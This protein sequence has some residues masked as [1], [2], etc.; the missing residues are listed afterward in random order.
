MM[1]IS[2]CL[3]LAILTLVGAAVPAHAGKE[4]IA[5]IVNQDVITKS[6]LNDRMKLISTSTGMPQTPELL[7]KLRPQIVNMLVE[8][9]LKM[10]EARRQKIEVTKEEIDAGF[11]Q[12]SGQN[13]IPPEEFKK[14]LKSHGIQMRTMEDQIRAQVAWG[15]VIQKKLRP[16][17]EISE[18]D[19]DSELAM[20]RDKIGKTEYR[21]ADIYLPVDDQKKDSEVSNVARRLVD[22]LRDQPNLFP[23]VAQQF[24]QA[25]GAQQGGMIGWISEGQLA[26]EID[27]VLPSLEVGAI[28]DAIKTMTGY[29]IILVREKRAITEETLPSREDL[30]Q[31]IGTSRL[32]RLQRRYLMDLQSTAYIES[33]V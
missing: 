32:D 33:R 10:Q 2:L 3:S 9:E 31:R 17:I 26:T 24:S 1:R 15:K 23:R 13:N 19:V 18:A 14:M 27:K 30:T 11:A 28:S 5:V 25:P 7:N 22:Q 16:Q 20:L 4:G 6:D 12:I 21:V 8:E 29:H